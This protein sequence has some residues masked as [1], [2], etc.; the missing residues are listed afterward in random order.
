MKSLLT[1]IVIGV[2]IASL[3]WLML[4]DIERRFDVLSS[5]MDRHDQVIQLILKIQSS[6][7]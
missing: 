6:N 7:Q 3:F 4:I 1:G 5:R 2:G